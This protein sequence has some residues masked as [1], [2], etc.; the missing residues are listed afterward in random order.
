MEEK[1]KFDELQDLL[2]VASCFNRELE[3][4]LDLERAQG[5]TLL[6][7]KA[8]NAQYGI[9]ELIKLLSK[10]R[11][12]G[13]YASGTSPVEN[14]A[15]K[16]EQEGIATE[17]ITFVDFATRKDDEEENDNLV[18]VGGPQEIMALE[19]A[20]YKAIENTPD[21]ENSF[22]VFDSISILLAYHGKQLV[23][24]FFHAITTE[25]RKKPGI[26]AVFISM[27]DQAEKEVLTRISQYCDE[28]IFL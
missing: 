12:T 13:I 17:G 6:G 11:N 19:I 4:K 27:D 23:E 28:T 9:I 2:S 3:E 16:F 5:I 10:G 1:D 21:N 8:E 14:L 24:K 26:N 7:L 20:I 22:F 25:L 15:A 18:Y